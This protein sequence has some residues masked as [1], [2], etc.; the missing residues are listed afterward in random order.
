[1]MTRLVSNCNVPLCPTECF[2]SDL[3]KYSTQENLNWTNYQDKKNAEMIRQAIADNN[4]S[5]INILEGTEKY[6]GLPKSI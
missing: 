2:Y 6:N 3:K 5:I 1:M 4:L